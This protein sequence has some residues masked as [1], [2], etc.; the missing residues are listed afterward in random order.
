M[1]TGEP[2]PVPK[3][4][5]EA[6][7]AGTV[8]HGSS[9]DLEVLAV[10]ADTQ[11]AR[12]AAM[13]AQA[14]G[15]RAPAQDLA[16]RISAVFVPAILALALLTFAG[17]AWR[18]GV[19]QAWRPAV[20]LLVIACPCALGLATPVA[21][22]VG[23][24]A[25]AR[26]GVLVRD[27]AALEALGQATDLVFDKTGTL[28]EGRPRLR[29]VVACGTLKDPDLLRLAASLERDSEHP[30]ARGIREAQGSDLLPVDG[31]R[32]HPGG[33]VSGD[34]AGTPWRLGNEA[35]LG[36]AFPP[37]DEDGTAVGLANEEGLQGVFILG[38]RLRPEAPEVVGALRRQGLRLHLLTGD[39]EAPA[40]LMARA[41]G[42][43]EVIAGVRPEG[44]LAYLKTL[45]EGGATVGFVGDGVNDA[46]ALA[47]A[48]CGI[49][50]GSGAGEQG[51]GAAMAAAPLVLLRSG[52]EPILAALALARRT[53]R[54]IRQN[55]GWAIGYN[56]LLVPLAAFGQLERFGGPMLAGVAMGLSS[57]TVVLNALRLR[58]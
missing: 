2:L 26:K 18:G 55:L 54:V 19:A 1:L 29:R 52:L 4:P 40:R 58:R 5:G 49:A 23:I 27:A 6:L 37:V 24:G 38:D 51:T 33:G 16:D 15:S 9:L 45:Q 43:E 44:K 30:I 50:M 11:L 35:F 7:V 41:A 20:T 14:Q 13:V 36:L 10:G 46:P 31:F 48:D 42:I 25:A 47:Q 53:H 39:R 34:V 21:V 12:M 32:S 8:V 17:W 56:L 3:E 28:T 57:L 22:M